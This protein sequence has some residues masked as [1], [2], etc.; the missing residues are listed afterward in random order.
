MLKFYILYSS[1]YIYGL[2]LKGLALHR[3]SQ[4]LHK[5]NKIPLWF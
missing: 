1:F 3:L 4:T 2:I 5:Y